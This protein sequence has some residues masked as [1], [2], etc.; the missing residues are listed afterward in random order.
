MRRMPIL[1]AALFATCLLIGSRAESAEPTEFKQPD[2]PENIERIG[3]KIQRTMTLLATSTPERRN[4]VKILFYGQS[5]TAGKWAHEVADYLKQKY[6]HA[7]LV[8]EN[9][10]IGGFG[11]EALLGT[12]EFDLYP[13]YPDLMIFH[14]YGG[15]KSGEWEEIIKRTRQRTAAEVLL[16][17]GHYRWP[18]DLDRDVPIDDPRARGEADELRA[19]MIRRVSK[20]YGCELAE[21]RLQ[22][23]K[24]CLQNKLCPSDLL[25]GWVHHNDR[26]AALMAALMKPYFRYDPKF[27]KDTWKALAQDI[28]VDGPD[29]KRG[30]DGSLEI[31][32]E[33]NRVDVI[34][35]HRKD[36]EL[37]TAKVL[38]DGKAPSQISEVYCFTRPSPAPFVW[39]P[40]IK[41]LSHEKPLVSEKWTAK[42]TGYDPEKKVMNFELTSS[43]TGP[44]GKGTDRERFVSR[45]G[46]VVIE[47]KA[48][49]VAGS[50]R[51]KKKTL[52]A[53]FEV[54]WEAKPQGVDT[55]LA[56]QAE[57]PSREYATTLAQGLSN[58]RHTLKIVPNDDGPVPISAIRAYCPPLK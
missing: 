31:G 47:P 14:V 10:A 28:P 43:L 30:P 55:Y 11:A 15:V 24:Y 19:E 18:E 37:G 26:G 57:D 35:A 2:P 6:P 49:M 52:P 48:W 23:K 50:L 21:I 20:E 36:V 41:Q 4:R 39:W 38:I 1:Q 54:T 42:I 13:F 44:E 7:D 22:W 8:I 46:R 33:G 9:L 25:H 34:A 5:V 3:S 16:W 53:G 40:G 27:S 45:N 56:P 17:T 51:Y 12:A 32:F 58:E 29:V